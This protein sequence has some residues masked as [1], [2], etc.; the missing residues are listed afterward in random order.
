MR[1]SAIRRIPTIANIVA[2]AFFSMAFPKT[3]VMLVINANPITFA[4]RLIIPHESVS[5]IP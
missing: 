3:G 2:T 1:I 5:S 4:V